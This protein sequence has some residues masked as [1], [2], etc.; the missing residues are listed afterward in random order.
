MWYSTRVTVARTGVLLAGAAFIEILPRA[1][2]GS[3]LEVLPLSQMLAGLVSVVASGELWP[4]LST[5][6]VSIGV[7]FA[8]AILAGV[9]SGYLLW[10]A[11]KA[12]SALSPY[13]VSY[14]AVPIFA[15]YPVLI[16]LFGANRKPIIL[17]AFAWAVVAV[18]VA[19]VEGLATMRSSWDKV[20]SVYHLG[21]L[22]RAV[23]VHLPGALPQIL[24]GVR[25]AATYCILGVIASEFILSGQ[26]MGYLVNLYFNQ[27]AFQEM[28]GAIL[29][30]FIVGV[31][32]DTT[33]R[34]TTRAA[35][36]NR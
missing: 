7:A 6:I 20:A 8:S 10:R 24:V 11:P 35:T 12:Y 13:L 33:V 25:L 3:D 21:P 14:Y 9:F 34:R 32:L 27:F 4:H 2:W 1:G 19:T 16:V 30:I 22:R 31:G 28:W 5:S 23:R 36:A 18:V 17:I 26:G 15:F 29:A